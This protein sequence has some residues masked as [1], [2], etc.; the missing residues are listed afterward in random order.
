[1]ANFGSSAHHSQ[2]FPVQQFMLENPQF[3]YFWNWEIDSRFTGHY[4]EF[5]DRTA[6]FGQKQPRRGIWER[7]ERFYIPTYHGNYENHFRAFVDAQSPSGVWGPVVM[8]PQS[9]GDE[10]QRLG[11]KPPASG[12]DA[13]NFHWGVGEQADLMVF[14]PIFNPVFTEWESQSEVYGYFAESTTR[15]AALITHCRISRRL[16]M[17]MDQENQEGRHMAVEMFHV[18]TALIHG[19]K[20]LSVPHPIYS[21]RL[22]PGDRVS[23]WF[24][25]GIDG[26]SGSS[27][28][29][30]FSRGRESRFKD[31]SWYTGANLPGRLYWNFLGWEKDGTGGP[32]VWNTKWFSLKQTRLTAANNGLVRE[33]TWATLSAFDPFSSSPRCSSQHG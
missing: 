9:I 13:D 8:G 12:V 22:M 6:T 20:A 18:S 33:R 1:M 24:N 29:S 7:S 31:V 14:L 3:E 32:K 11:P 4:Y 28:D 25:S 27:K 21:D 15:R 10:V 5:V 19:F 16:L 30:A 26:R 23:R 17:A 2:W